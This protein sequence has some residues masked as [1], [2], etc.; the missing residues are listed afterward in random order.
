MS[1]EH[2]HYHF[3][4]FPKSDAALLIIAIAACWITSML[5]TGNGC[6]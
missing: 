6:F 4:L 3:H 5:T 2:K 1:D